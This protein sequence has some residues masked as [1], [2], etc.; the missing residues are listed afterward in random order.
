[1]SLQRGI[2]FTL[3]NT[4]HFYSSIGATSG[5]NGITHVDRW[6]DSGSLTCTQDKL[7]VQSTPN[8]S[9]L[10]GKIE[11]G[12]SCQEF[13]LSIRSKELSSNPL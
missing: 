6:A 7:H 5:M 10:Q 4:R 8:N 12:S 13:E 9:N 3:S 1:M 2:D 11:K